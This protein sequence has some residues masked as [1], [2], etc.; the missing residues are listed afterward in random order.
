V[1]LADPGDVL[2]SEPVAVLLGD[3]RETT[4]LGAMQI[5]GFAEPVVVARLAH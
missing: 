2:V 5:R 4:S 1:A 3:R